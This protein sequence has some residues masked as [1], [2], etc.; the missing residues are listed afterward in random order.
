VKYE[1]E[2]L[3]RKV[4][5][6]KKFVSIEKILFVCGAFFL[7]N[8]YFDEFNIVPSAVAGIILMIAS[9][10]IKKYSSKWSF[11]FISALL[12]TVVSVALEVSRYNFNEAYIK[13]QIMR[14]SQAFYAWEQMTEISIAFGV[15]SALTVISLMVLLRDIAI[16]YTGYFMKGTD[17]FDPERATKEL[18]S[19][20]TKPLI[21]TGIFGVLQSALI[22]IYFIAMWYRFEAIWFFDIVFAMIFAFCLVQNLNDIS[23]NIN[24]KHFVGDE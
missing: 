3:P 15:A 14:N 24:F 5:F 22:P 16:K 23:K 6:L 13:E 10:R 21:L 19:E 18:H 4:L 1:T 20:L 12:M 11:T 17:A 8:L 9:Y 2:V 7:T